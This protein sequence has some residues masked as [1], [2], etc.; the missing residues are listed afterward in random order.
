MTSPD[1]QLPDCPECPPDS[2]WA[3]LTPIQQQV[4][5][6]SAIERTFAAGATLMEEGETGDH[7]VVIFVGRTKICVWEGGT[8]QII[9]KRGPGELVGERAALRVSVR[10]ATVVALEQVEALVMTTADFASFLSRY[11]DVVSVVEDQIYERLTRDPTRRYR[12]HLQHALDVGRAM[13]PRFSRPASIRLVGENCT[14][15]FTDVVA[16]G[17]PIRNDE[18]RRIIRRELLRMT[19]E[20]LQTIWGQCCWEDRGDGH[21]IVVPPSV[22]TVQV[23]RALSI[24][25]PDA[26][27]RHNELYGAGARIQLKIALDVGPVTGDESGVSGQV[28]INA[29]RYLDASPLKEAMAATQATVGFVL[30]DFV[31]E[32]AVSLAECPTDPIGYSSIEVQVKEIYQRAWMLLFNQAPT[33]PAASALPPIVTFS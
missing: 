12:D 29:A 3:T 28:I 14:V 6:Q 4:F 2:F 15:V 19:F 24:A 23:L 1:S 20:A 33:P 8:E 21:L 16:F 32:S 30:S 5:T 18:H 27:R 11:P 10:S 31:F 25:L 26:L 17:S 22:P 7:V 9:A 13:V